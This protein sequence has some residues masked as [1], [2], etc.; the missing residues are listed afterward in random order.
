M[1]LIGQGDYPVQTRVSEANDAFVQGETPA[2]LRYACVSP[3]HI[4]NVGGQVIWQ[5]HGL[6]H[7]GT[8]E[9]PD[10][11]SGCNGLRE[12]RHWDC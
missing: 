8:V 5:C 10:V 11:G 1:W 7:D 2:T 6:S 9:V 4:T 3:V 12:Q